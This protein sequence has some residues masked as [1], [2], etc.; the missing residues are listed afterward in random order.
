VDPRI[1]G[2]DAVLTKIF[3]GLCD[4]DRI[5]V[6]TRLGHCVLHTYTV[7]TKPQPSAT[8]QVAVNK[9]HGHCALTYGGG[10]SLHR[11]MTHITGRKQTWEIGF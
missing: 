3:S 10:V 5:Q 1:A 6:C 2:F 9:G 4:P 7:A 11:A 8:R